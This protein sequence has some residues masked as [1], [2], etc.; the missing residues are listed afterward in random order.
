M[1]DA[2]GEENASDGRYVFRFEAITRTTESMKMA[3]FRHRHNER[4]KGHLRREHAHRPSM[5]VYLTFP[6]YIGCFFDLR[7]T[8]RRIYGVLEYDDQ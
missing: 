8:H 2:A 5:A 7:E 1:R 4:V 6:H 3:R